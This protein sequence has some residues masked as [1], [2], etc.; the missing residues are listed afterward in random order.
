MEVIDL[1]RDDARKDYKCYLLLEKL[2]KENAEFR[3]I[4]TDGVLNGVIA[5][6]TADI[7]EKIA[8]QNI[9]GIDS[10]EDVF[11]DGANIGYCTVAAKQL[12]YS[13]NGCFLCGGVVSYL[14]DTPNCKDGSHTWLVVNGKIID[15]SLM[16][17][18]DEN[19]SKK[20]GYVEENRYN[21]M[22]DPFYVAAKDFTLD[23][24]LRK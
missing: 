20:L 7:W 13:F 14:K 21:P 19:Y 5:G 11:R 8:A 17:V 16:I 24:N 10:F 23:K 9:R 6:Y 3:K 18:I 4:I 12:S 22:V 15:T 1:L 2:L